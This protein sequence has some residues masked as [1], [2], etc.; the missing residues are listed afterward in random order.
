MELNFKEL[1]TAN[2][3]RSEID[4]NTPFD[5]LSPAEWVLLITGELGEVCNAISKGEPVENILDEIADVVIYADILAQR[6]GVIWV[7]RL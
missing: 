1:S 6:F 3:T 7:K 5:K 2:K 4:F